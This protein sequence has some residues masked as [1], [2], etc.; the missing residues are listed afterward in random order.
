MES[1]SHAKSNEMLDITIVKNGT[2]LQLVIL[3]LFNQINHSVKQD[4][5]IQFT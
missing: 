2:S 5:L 1:A 3:L 4:S